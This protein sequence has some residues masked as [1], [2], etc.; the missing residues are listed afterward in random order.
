M[1]DHICKEKS[2]EERF[3]IASNNPDKIREIREMLT[4]IRASVLT[5]AEM[6][7]RFD[8]EETGTTFEENALLKAHSLHRFTGGYVM[9]DDSGLSINALNGAPGILSARF[10]GENASYKNKIEKIWKLLD[11]CEN[12]DRSASFICAIAVVLPD[13]SD[14]TVRGECNGIIQDKIEGENGFGY[15]PVFYMP[16][17]KMTT[18]SMSREMKNEISHRGKA[19]RK[20]LEKLQLT[21]NLFSR[22]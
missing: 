6:G 5:P 22:C 16:E 2:M 17:Y 20:M 10:A 4:G 8:V 19:L 21:T 13:G 15:D 11:E 1:N 7:I 18:A 14:F 3:I 12:K 9:A